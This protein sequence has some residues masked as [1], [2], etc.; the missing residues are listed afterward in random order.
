MQDVLLTGQF[1]QI[2]VQ[3]DGPVAR[4]KD[5]IIFEIEKLVGRYILGQDER[6]FGLEHSREDDVMEDD[7]VFANKMYDLCFA[8]F[9]PRFPI[10]VLLKSTGRNSSSVGG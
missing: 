9:P 2:F 7:V 4:G 6:A 10:A 5:F 1:F 3:P 8:V